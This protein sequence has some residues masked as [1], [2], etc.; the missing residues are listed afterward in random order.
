VCHGNLAGDGHHHRN[1]VFAGADRVA[2]RGVHD[3][4]AVAAGGFHVDIVHADA[5]AADHAQA[6]GAGGDDVRRGLAAA[7]HGPTVVFVDTILDL[8][9]R[10]GGKVVDFEAGIAKNV[11]SVL[12]QLVTYQDAIGHWR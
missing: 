3:D 6:L 9:L 7:A 5:G 8:V 1:R 11:E 10:Q 12:A 2:T 4:D